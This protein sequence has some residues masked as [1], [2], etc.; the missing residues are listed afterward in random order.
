MEILSL[1]SSNAIIRLFDVVPKN[2]SAEQEQNSEPS[3]AVDP[4]DPAQIIAGSFA[5]GTPLGASPPVIGNSMPIEM[6]V[7][8]PPPLAPALL[9]LLLLQ[10]VTMSTAPAPSTPSLVSFMHEPSSTRRNGGAKPGDHHPP[11]PP[12][13]RRSVMGA[14]R[15]RG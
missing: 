13:G 2:H 3:L 15:Y 9:P 5:V 11:Q 1:G 4:I 10:P 6:A 14:E 12:P 7:P 8:L